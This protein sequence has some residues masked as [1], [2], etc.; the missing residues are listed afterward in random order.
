MGSYDHF[1]GKEAN[2]LFMLSYWGDLDD[3]QSQVERSGVIGEWLLYHEDSTKAGFVSRTRDFNGYPTF[4]LSWTKENGNL[5]FKGSGAKLFLRKFRNSELDPLANLGRLDSPDR[6]L[7]GLYLGSHEAALNQKELRIREISHI[8]T[9]GR[10]L[11]QPFTEEINYKLIEAWD[12]PDQ[13]MFQ[14]FEDC[15]QFINEGRDAG[16]VL[17]HCAAGISRSSTIVLAYIMR[18]EGLSFKDAF[19]LVFSRHFICPNEGFIKQLIQWEKLLI[20]QGMIE[21]DQLE[22]EENFY[23]STE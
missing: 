16:G 10:D 21:L 13:N 15:I 8:L 23:Y 1:G 6:I 9:V 20:E 3:L 7:D 2:K 12:D 4:S 22:D 5:I 18:E 14:H 17:I 19:A 11:S